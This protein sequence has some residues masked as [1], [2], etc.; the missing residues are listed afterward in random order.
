MADEGVRI[1]EANSRERVFL[2]YPSSTDTVKKFYGTTKNESSDDEPRAYCYH[3][4]LVL[5]KALLFYYRHFFASTGSRQR[6]QDKMKGTLIR[7][8][9]ITNV[10]IRRLLNLQETLDFK[11]GSASLKSLVKNRSATGSKESDSDMSL[12]NSKQQSV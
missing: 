9:E 3:P 6:M 2:P 4:V 11:S 1:S 10:E 8:T 7:R 5:K 12:M